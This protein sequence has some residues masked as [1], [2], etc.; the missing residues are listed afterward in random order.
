[1]PHS[2]PDHSIHQQAKALYVKSVL[3]NQHC[4]AALLEHY[5]TSHEKPSNETWDQ[6]LSRCSEQDFEDGE[7]GCCFTAFWQSA[8]KVAA[9]G[10]GYPNV[11]RSEEH[12][13]ELLSLMRL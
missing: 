10:P 5:R 12:T 1:M 3:A 6:F 8:M 2:Q 4:V 11:Y 9:T 7:Q 13:S